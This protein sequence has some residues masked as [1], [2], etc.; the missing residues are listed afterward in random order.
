MYYASIEGNNPNEYYHQ[1]RLYRDSLSAICDIKN[2]VKENTSMMALALL[3]YAEGNIDSAYQEKM[4]KQKSK[5]QKYLLLVSILSV[6]LTFA[7]IYVFRQMKRITR[8]RKE[9]HQTNVKLNILN[10]DLLQSNIKLQ[11]LNSVCK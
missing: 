10:T 8:I 5:L 1:N 7:M 3:L 4:A 2:A 9:L 11:E 6:F